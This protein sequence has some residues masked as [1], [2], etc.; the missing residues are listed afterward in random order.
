MS[1]PRD[2]RPTNVDL[3]QATVKGGPFDNTTTGYITSLYGP[4]DPIQ[5]P[6]TGIW[7]PAWHSGLDIAVWPLAS[8]VY[9][10]YALWGGIVLAVDGVNDDNGYSVGVMDFTNNWYF[11]YY[12]LAGAPL[13]TIG[14]KIAAGTL[15]GYEGTTGY[16]TGPHLHLGI[17]YQYNYIDPLPIL[18]GGL[19]IGEFQGYII[20]S[21]YFD[22]DGG[23]HDEY[24]NYA[25]PR[26]GGN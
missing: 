14:Q 17:M 18:V 23:Y 2:M 22:P 26:S 6:D 5:D 13:V 25:P 10:L 7:L 8:G 9:P 11:E 4:R 21:N 19:D 12:H 15:L 24:G 3:Y 1:A 20:G 16:S